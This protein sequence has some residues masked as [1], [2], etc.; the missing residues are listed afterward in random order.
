MGDREKMETAKMNGMF[1]SQKK[2]NRI[3]INNFD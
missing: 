1:C 3:E 2:K